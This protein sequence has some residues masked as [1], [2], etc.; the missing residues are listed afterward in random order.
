MNVKQTFI[1]H[2]L[3]VEFLNQRIKA[4]QAVICDYICVVVK[5]T[6]MIKIIIIIIMKQLLKMRITSSYWILRSSVIE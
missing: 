3:Q 2:S 1:F 5:G 6:I 4:V